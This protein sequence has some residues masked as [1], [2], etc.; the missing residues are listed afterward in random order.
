MLKIVHYNLFIIVFSRCIF[1]INYL[2]RFILKTA[3]RDI[4]WIC[5]SSNIK[6]MMR[7]F[8]SNSTYTPISYGRSSK[9]VQQVVP[10]S[11]CR[12][13]FLKAV[14][15]I[16]NGGDQKYKWQ[17]HMFWTAHLKHRNSIQ[18]CSAYMNGLNISRYC[19]W[20]PILQR[21]LD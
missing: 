6:L 14:C 3:Y 10:Y 15:R 2:A 8:A 7:K 4:E 5:H 20:H 11:K 21:T 17:R 18:I 19:R 1:H 16:R 9:W 13:N 12:S